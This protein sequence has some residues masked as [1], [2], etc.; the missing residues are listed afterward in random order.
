MAQEFGIA[1]ISGIAIANV[2]KRSTVSKAN[3]WSTSGQQRQ[4]SLFKTLSED[5]TTTFIEG[6]NSASFKVSGSNARVY[7]P[8]TFNGININYQFVFNISGLRAGG[9]IC[10][11]S[12]S[13]DFANDI[14]AGVNI[15][16]S[17]GNK[18]I[19]VN[20]GSTR[21]RDVYI[22]IWNDP[23]LGNRDTVIVSDLLVNIV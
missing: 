1:S 8:Y 14:F 4:P 3:I 18:S 7:F 15:G 2:G 6:K 19:V 9:W 22:G 20:S 11:I 5:G 17:D 12:T 10:A 23:N 21:D 13:T 16:A